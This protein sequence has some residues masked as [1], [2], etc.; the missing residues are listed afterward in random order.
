MNRNRAD[1]I[2][3][4]HDRNRCTIENIKCFKSAANETF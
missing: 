2:I 3:R 1:L 4:R